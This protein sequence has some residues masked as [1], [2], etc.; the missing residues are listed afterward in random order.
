MGTGLR[1]AEI[2]ALEQGI[3]PER[4]LRN[5]KTFDCAAQARL[6][7]TKVAMVG[8]GGLGGHILDG[9][10]RLGFGIISAADHDVFEPSNLNRQL[11]ATQN[12]IGASKAG[13]AKARLDEVNPAVELHVRQLYVEPE[14]FEEFYAG[15]DIAIDALGG[16]ACRPAAERGAAK[17]GVPLI[18]AAVAGWTLLAATVL[19]GGKGPAGYFCP[20]TKAKKPSAED[21]LGC[22]T[23]AIHVAAGL[24]LAEAVRIALGKPPQLGGPGGRMVAM[25]LERMSLERFSLPT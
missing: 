6:L 20:E 13:T 4:Y 21:S 17:A 11:L 5:F 8:L 10:A 23:P 15:V 9:L 25:D 22:L 2:T 24:V 7:N 16:A 19:P 14:D 12:S 18:T 1:L 3:I